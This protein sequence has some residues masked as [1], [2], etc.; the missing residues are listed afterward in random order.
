MN[1]GSTLGCR[2][3]VWCIS[4]GVVATH[5]KRPDKESKN[6]RTYRGASIPSD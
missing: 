6:R 3:E 5:C 4:L 2:D 1:Q